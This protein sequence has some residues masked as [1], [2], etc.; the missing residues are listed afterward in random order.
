MSI[1]YSVVMIVGEDEEFTEYLLDLHHYLTSITACHELILVFNGPNESA[2]Q[3]FESDW[4]AQGP[5]VLMVELHRKVYS[6]TCLQSLLS[7]CRGEILLIC[8]PYRQ[9][10]DEGLVKMLNAVDSGE[11]DLALPWRQSRVDPP[12]NQL[13]SWLFNLLV[14]QMTA[15]RIHDLNCAL[16]IVRRTVLEESTFHGDLY[17][18]LP[19]MA[20]K[21]GFKIIEIPTPHVQEKGKVGYF[22]LRVYINRLVDL[23]TIHFNLN[24]A[25]KP[26]RYFGFRGGVLLLLGILLLTYAFVARAAG[27][28]SLGNSPLLMTGLFSVLA[29]SGL[30]GVGL[31]G[32]ILV[33]ALGRKR[34][35]YVIE[36]I[37]D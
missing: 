6:G 23:L 11:A 1:D 8:G 2:R 13:Q 22:G 35:D 21:R 12:I 29:G 14:Y 20:Q 36:T 10:A 18:F 9:V 5:E 17:R 30:W 7:D 25:R 24:F 31:L 16:R 32:E 33:F 4:P 34:K 28:D 26:L 37:L 3:R 15:V 27:I 19:L